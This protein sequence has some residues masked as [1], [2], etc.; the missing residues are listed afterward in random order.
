MDTGAFASGFRLEV[1]LDRPDRF[2][3]GYDDWGF[4]A[5]RFTGL[6]TTTS[7]GSW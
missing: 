2:I 6:L 1:F 4:L 5:S 7:R 3:D